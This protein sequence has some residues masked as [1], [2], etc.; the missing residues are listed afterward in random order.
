MPK[1]S[2]GSICFSSNSSEDI[3]QIMNQMDDAFDSN[4][5]K[6]L[7]DKIQRITQSILSNDHGWWSMIDLK[8]ILSRESLAVEIGQT[9]YHDPRIKA[10]WIARELKAKYTDNYRII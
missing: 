6:R 4:T 1:R 9:R 3:K 7:N 5:T 10:I 2:N 8:K